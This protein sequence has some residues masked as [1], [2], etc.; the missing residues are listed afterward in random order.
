MIY[1]DDCE[2]RYSFDEVCSMP[3]HQQYV[4]VLNLCPVCGSCRTEC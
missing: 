3:M 4:A 1:C 2:K